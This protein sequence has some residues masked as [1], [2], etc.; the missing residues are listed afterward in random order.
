MVYEMGKFVV[1]E[2]ICLRPSAKNAYPV[3][4]QEIHQFLSQCIINDGDS[5]SV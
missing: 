5:T 2:P 4:D 1:T 3:G